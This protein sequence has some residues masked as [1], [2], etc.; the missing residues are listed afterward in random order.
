MINL[1]LRCTVFLC[2]DF[3]HKANLSIR[4]GN[5][6]SFSEKQIV[7]NEKQ[8]LKKILRN[9]WNVFDVTERVKSL[10][11][12]LK[13]WEGGNFRLYKNTG[14]QKYWNFDWLVPTSSIQNLDKNF[15]FTEG[16]ILFTISG[17]KYKVVHNWLICRV[18][19]LFVVFGYDV[20]LLF[21]YQT[22]SAF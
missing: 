15:Q 1:I 7:K 20:V 5:G 14:N 3:I 8:I 11:Y 22:T 2:L 16:I 4:K 12:V 9:K 6:K 17:D 10:F 19:S 21:V 18:G 13:L